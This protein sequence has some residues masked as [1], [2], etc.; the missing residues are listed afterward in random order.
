MQSSF[1]NS[2]KYLNVIFNKRV[3]WRLHIEVIE[4]KAFRTFITIYFLFKSERLSTNIKLTFHKALIRTIVAYA[5]PVSEFVAVKHLPKLQRLQNKV[6]CTIGKFPRRMPGREFHMS[7]KLPYIYDYVAKLC[8][9]HVEVIQNHENAN[10][11]N[12]GQGEPRHRKYK[13]LKLRG[14]QVYDRSSD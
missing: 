4:A 2:V 6:L 14:G 8:R 13:G 9:Q 7:F 3:T 12:I 1:V 10:V 11:C 5:C